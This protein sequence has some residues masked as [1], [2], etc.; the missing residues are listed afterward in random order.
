MSNGGGANINWGYERENPWT[1]AENLTGYEGRAMRIT[2]GN[3]VGPC[4]L[5]NQAT[6]QA[7][8]TGVGVLVMG[9]PNE[10][11]IQVRVQSGGRVRAIAGTGGV[12]AGARCVPEY[13]ASG[14]DRGR[15]IAR[16]T[17]QVAD[18]DINWGHAEG[19]ASEDGEFYLIMNGDQF[20]LDG[21][22]A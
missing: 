15:F 12:T 2:S 21:T 8:K 9:G 5:T 1:P 19:A 22:G 7:L 4:S 11:G 10:T 20:T 18:G 16:T 13:V 3:A 17:A 14:L 6:T